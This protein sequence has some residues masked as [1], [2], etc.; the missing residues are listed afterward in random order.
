MTIREATTADAPEILAMVRELAE[1]ERSAD[2]VQASTAD[3]E[4]ALFSP[5]PAVH[6]HVVED[7]QGLAGFALWFVTFSTW[8]GRHGIYLEDLY[9]RPGQRGQ[10][11]GRALLAQ[12]AHVCVDR[13]YR[14]LEWSVLDWNVDAIGFYRRLGSQTKDGWTVHRLHGSALVELAASAPP[15]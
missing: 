1:Y 12:L 13:D 4:R 10:G 5:A 6:C 8:T 9:V 15:R 3:L 14:R 2:E 7:A 11:Y